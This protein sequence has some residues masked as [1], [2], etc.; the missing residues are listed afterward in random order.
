MRPR[1]RAFALAAGER[2]VKT[3]AQTLAAVIVVDKVTSLVGA[4]W[5]TYLGAA[6]LAALLSVL[7]SVASGGVGQQGPSLTTETTTPATAV[8]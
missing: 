7:S 3:F 8:P 4:D 6:G 5:G 1:L 2:A